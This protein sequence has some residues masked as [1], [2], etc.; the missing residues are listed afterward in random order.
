MKYE[1]AWYNRH[2]CTDKKGHIFGMPTKEQRKEILE[3]RPKFNNGV[4]IWICV[5]CNKICQSM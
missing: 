4:A 3:E 2:N 5:F 1:I